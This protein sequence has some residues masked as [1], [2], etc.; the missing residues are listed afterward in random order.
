MIERPLYSAIVYQCADETLWM[1]V[2]RELG[3]DT[4]LLLD[5]AEVTGELGAVT[6]DA[7]LARLGHVRVGGEVWS[8][9]DESGYGDDTLL[10]TAGVEPTADALT[11][12]LINPPQSVVNYLNNNGKGE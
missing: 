12:F 10:R 8:E 9:S 5:V 4:E 1:D 7:T 6:L 2:W 3:R 11:R